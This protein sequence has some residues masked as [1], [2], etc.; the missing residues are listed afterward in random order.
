[1]FPIDLLR[2]I[3]E[4]LFFSAC[5]L[6]GAKRAIFCYILFI[7]ALSS[8]LKDLRGVI[9]V[10]ITRRSRVRMKQFL[11]ILTKYPMFTFDV[12]LVFLTK[13]L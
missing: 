4:S 8:A 5:S 6:L 9:V 11:R 2:V 7:L 12:F 3:R 10:A 1:M 13:E